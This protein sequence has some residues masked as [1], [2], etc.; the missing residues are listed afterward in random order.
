VRGRFQGWGYA[1]PEAVAGKTIEE[2]LLPGN[3]ILSTLH[4]PVA[5][6]LTNVFISGTFKGK[7]NDWDGDGVIDLNSRDVYSTVDGEIDSNQDGIADEP[8]RTCCDYTNL[9]P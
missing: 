7:L 3:A 6:P 5:G 9:L 8:G 2:V 4:D 1:N